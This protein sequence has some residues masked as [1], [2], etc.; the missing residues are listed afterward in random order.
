MYDC[1]YSVLHEIEENNLAI[2][3]DSDGKLTEDLQEDRQQIRQW[4]K[5]DGEL[6]MMVDDIIVGVKG[7]KH[8]VKTI[9]DAQDIINQKTKKGV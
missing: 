8:K 5:K 4:K 6:D 2:H 3:G 9:N 7:L 1:Q